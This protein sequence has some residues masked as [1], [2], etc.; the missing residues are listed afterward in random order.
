MIDKLL[1]TCIWMKN[2]NH[3]KLWWE[4]SNLGIVNSC[5]YYHLIEINATK[6]IGTILHNC[7]AE[8]RGKWGKA[9]RLSDGWERCK[10]V[11]PSNVKRPSEESLIATG[12]KLVACCKSSSKYNCYIYFNPCVI[13]PI[14]TLQHLYYELEAYN[15]EHQEI[16]FFP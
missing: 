12:F 15:I 4:H 7:P 8:T 10:F 11:I 1:F 16:D 6:H 5:S 9:S 2:W 13:T 14:W 3:H